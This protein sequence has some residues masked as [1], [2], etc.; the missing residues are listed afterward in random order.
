MPDGKSV[1]VGLVGRLLRSAVG[2][3][4][5]HQQYQGRGADAGNC[6]SMPRICG[7]PCES[8]PMLERQRQRYA[9]LLAAQAVQIAACNRLHEG[10]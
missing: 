2:C 7:A 8:A 4:R 3:R 1:E 6:I 9:Q 5:S 10:G